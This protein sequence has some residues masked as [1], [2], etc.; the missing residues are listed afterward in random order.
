MNIYKYEHYKVYMR[1]WIDSQ[2]NNGRGQLNLMAKAI[3]VKAS[4]LSAIMSTERNITMEQAFELNSFFK[5]DELQSEFFIVLVSID[6]AGTFKLKDYY[7]NQKSVLLKKSEQIKKRIKFENSISETQRES[8]Y[9]KSLYSYVRMLSTLDKG[10][11]AQ[12][13]IQLTKQS[14]KEIKIV[15]DDL[16]SF[17]LIIEKEKRFYSTN[18]NIHIAKESNH[19]IHHRRN[20]LLEQI[21]KHPNSSNSNLHFTCPCTLSRSDFEKI[22][23]ILLD[24]IS[25]T[26]KIIDQSPAEFMACLTID[27][28]NYSE[29]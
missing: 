14:K 5:H 26:H 21:N 25:K 6:R 28:I 8:Y 9:S 19:Y 17:G 15:V 2:P 22:K 1:E 12:E 18:Q 16:L 29:D 27:L 4:L 11:S 10:V 7:G 20:W 23:T 24:S 3:N 13:I